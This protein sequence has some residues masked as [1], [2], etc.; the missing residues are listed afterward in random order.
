M[1]FNSRQFN[2]THNTF[3]AISTRVLRFTQADPS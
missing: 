3:T 2:N 1:T